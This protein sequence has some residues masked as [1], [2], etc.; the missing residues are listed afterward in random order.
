[1]SLARSHIETMFCL[2]L[3]CE[4]LKV[5][6]EIKIRKGLWKWQSKR[7]SV[8]Q[9]RLHLNPRVKDLLS[10]LEVNLG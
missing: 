9:L 4:K 5:R 8:R 7:L 10:N 6:V 1:M 3:Y 2:P